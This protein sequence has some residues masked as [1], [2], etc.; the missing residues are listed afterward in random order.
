MRNL[1]ID[2][3]EVDDF[4]VLIG[5]QIGL[6]ILIPKVLPLLEKEPFVEGWYYEG[7]LLCSVLRA[8]HQ[9]YSSNPEIRNRVEAIV[10]VTQSKISELDSDSIR[11]INEA[12]RHGKWLTQIET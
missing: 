6:N 2:E 10:A 1:N 3:F 8:E 7:D 5:Q 11:Y 12:V 4:R 9:Y